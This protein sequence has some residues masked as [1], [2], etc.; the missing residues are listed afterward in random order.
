MRA[1]GNIPLTL[2]SME[3]VAQNYDP[4]STYTGSDGGLG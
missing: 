2:T 1:D 3:G 4:A